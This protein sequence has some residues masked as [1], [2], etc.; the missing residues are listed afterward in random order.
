MSNWTPGPIVELMVTR[1]MYVP[2]LVC[3]LAARTLS[4]KARTF[5]TILSPVNEALPT[6]PCT[7]APAS[8]RYSTLP[9][10]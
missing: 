8:T 6:G 10:L 7:L 9:P 4:T 2:L 1:R 3:G 5:S